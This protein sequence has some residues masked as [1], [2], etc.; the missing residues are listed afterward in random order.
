MNVEIT[1]LD[2]D[3][4]TLSKLTRALNEKQF[5]SLLIFYVK[6]YD[7]FHGKLV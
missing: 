4:S 6:E 3:Q 5:S 1:Y 7:N 2:L